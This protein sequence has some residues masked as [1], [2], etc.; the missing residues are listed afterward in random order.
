VRFLTILFF[1]IQSLLQFVLFLILFAES[2]AMRQRQSA[3]VLFILLAIPASV[4]GYWCLSTFNSPIGYA[5]PPEPMDLAVGDIS[6]DGSPDIIVASRSGRSLSIFRGTP[7][8]TFVR[9][10][11]ISLPQGS[12]SVTIADINHDSK[13]DI[14][15]IICDE[16]C[17]R[18]NVLFFPGRGDG[19][20]NEPIDFPVAGT[21]SKLTT[22]DLNGDGMLDLIMA[23][24]NL[25]Q[26][27]FLMSTEDGFRS[28]YLSTPEPPLSFDLHDVNGDSLL[29]IAVVNKGRRSVTVFTNT[30]RA[31]APFS[32][33]DIPIQGSPADA[34]FVDVNS[35]GHTDLAV[36][37]SDRPGKLS[38]FEG[39]GNGY[40]KPTFQTSVEEL[41]IGIHVA[42]FNNDKS[43]DLL[44]AF[45]NK[46]FASLHLNTGDGGFSTRPSRV[47][48]DQRISSLFVGNLNGD[49][50]PDVAALHFEN[51]SLSTS[52]G[53]IR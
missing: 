10:R 44:V 52:L 3:V 5:L 2:F 29:D 26:M 53:G 41:P 37:H 20:F 40:F 7:R 19:K 31:E 13:Q 18:N 42:D 30:G 17:Y 36:V 33:R 34:K 39:A 51:P 35:D 45:K 22:A 8:G 4:L 49:S 16:E 43:P 32:R 11:K 50:T 47:Q 6:G 27:T 38:L 21:P 24:L 23:N 46:R 14:V 9:S 28:A 15:A 25:A 1:S 48:M 12:T